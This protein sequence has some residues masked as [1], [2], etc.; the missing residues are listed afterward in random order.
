MTDDTRN[1]GKHLTIIGVTCYLFFAGVM[2]W[3][4][5]TNDVKPISELTNACAP[6]QIERVFV[7]QPTGLSRSIR[8]PKLWVQTR[9]GQLGAD[10]GERPYWLDVLRA[11]REGRRVCFWF[12]ANSRTHQMYQ[13]VIEDHPPVLDYA[14]VARSISWNLIA[15]LLM[16][17]LGVFIAVPY[18]LLKAGK[19]RRAI[20]E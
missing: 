13:I 18:L 6:G 20:R 8:S 9:A 12:D 5:L 4:K 7:E 14:S 3:E 1:K 17:F 10:H 2:A 15:L 11:A 19:P 16:G